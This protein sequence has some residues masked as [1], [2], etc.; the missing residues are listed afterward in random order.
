METGEHIG[1]VGLGYVGLPLALALARH[2]PVTG[3]DTDSTRLAELAQGIDR[4]GLADAEALRQ[5]SLRT[6]AA[7][8]EAAD[9]TVYIVTAPTPVHDDH[10]PNWSLLEKAARDVGSVLKKGDLVVFESTVCPGS[11]EGRCI[12]ILQEQSGLRVNS[13]FDCAYSPERISLN[14]RG[15]GDAVKIIS[16]SNP[17]ARARLR[18]LYEKIVPAGLHE[19]PSI[20]VA[21]AAKLA[22]NI[23]RDVE[24]ATINELAM[25]YG[26]WGIDSAAVLDAAATKW[27]FRRFTPGLV[28]GHCIGTDSYYLL[29]RAARENLPA[30]LLRAARQVNNAVPLYVAEQITAQVR[31]RGQRPEE[32]PLLLLGYAF[33]EN[34]GDVRNTLAEP[35]RRRLEESGFPV[36]VCDPLADADHARAHYG[37]TLL[38]DIDAALGAKPQVAVFAVA[39]RCFADIPAAALEGLFVADI[40]GIAARADWRL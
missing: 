35:L 28:G 40:K 9:C 23:Q 29:E 18:R 26:Q 39:H 37:V 33:K 32:S 30:P 8:A 21:E 19:A 6:A 10:R 12:P 2:H 31:Q 34:C 20:Q 13:G 14:D 24:I 27:N 36:Q 25:L 7:I 3:V 5:S 15:L 17:A 11:T 38:A 1:V 16:A 4:G 22:E